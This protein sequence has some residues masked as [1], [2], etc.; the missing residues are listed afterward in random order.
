MAANTK[1]ARPALEAGRLLRRVGLALMALLMF[2]AAGLTGCQWSASRAEEAPLE[3]SPA[4]ARGAGPLPTATAEPATPAPPAARFA[5][6]PTP[7]PPGLSAV[8][9]TPAQAG[10]PVTIALDP[11]HGG[12]DSGA[13]Y[14]GTIE[15][16]A[17]LAIALR[18]ADLLR[19]GG[20]Q[21]ALTRDSDRAVNDPPQDWNGDRQVNNRDE[22][23]AR[24]DI[25]NAA[26]ASVFVS[27]HNNGSSSPAESGTEVWWSPDRPFADDN[28]R[29][30]AGIQAAILR[31]LAEAGYQSPD[32]GIKSDHAFRIWNGRPY[33]L[34]VLGPATGERHPR[35]TEMPGILGETLFVSNPAESQLL[36]QPRI[37]E[38]LAMGYR[39][40]ILAYLGR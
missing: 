36:Q 1:A 22:L 23:Q 20:L 10:R 34:F 39:D 40:G 26:S 38:A 11:G 9:A 30:A 31:R 28:Y 2:G 18:L 33:N 29:L 16:D 37:I 24:V 17:N 3:A 35:A 14:G 19:A 5:P 27:I 7:E 32:R 8:P 15:K 6:S 13:G 12:P 25:A 4:A 21:V